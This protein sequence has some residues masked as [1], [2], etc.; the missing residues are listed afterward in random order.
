M[1]QRNWSKEY[2]KTFASMPD[3]FK[4]IYMENIYDLVIDEEYTDLR[5][6]VDIIGF[7]EYCESPIEQILWLTL[8][9]YALK[10]N[11]KYV[12]EEQAEIEANGKSYRIDFLYQEDYEED[13][14]H[15]FRLAIECDGHD[16]HEKT[17][18]QVIKRN[19]RDMDLKMAGYDVLHYSGSQI[20]K[21]PMGC[22]IDI[23]DYITK[24]LK[25]K[26][27]ETNKENR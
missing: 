16:Y 24:Q 12:F 19:K 25:E 8:N 10:F 1:G 9:L 2:S 18:E 17:K 5:I 3:K 11:K 14:E 27:H 4:E 23:F 20:F 13:I 26:G 6:L 21:K 7:P 22:V 15:P